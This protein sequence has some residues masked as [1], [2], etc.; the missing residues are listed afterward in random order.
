M[1]D[2]FPVHFLYSYLN[3]LL[4]QNRVECP[5]DEYHGNSRKYLISFVEMVNIVVLLTQTLLLRHF[6]KN[7]HK[8]QVG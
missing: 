2:L 1:I 4:I 7:S 3:R 6:R 8:F 5:N